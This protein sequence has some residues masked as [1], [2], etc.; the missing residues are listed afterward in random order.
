MRI[1]FLGTRANIDPRSR[2]HR[3]HAAL[4]I[5]H[6][7]RRVIIDCGRDWLGRQKR[8]HADAIVVTHAHPDHVVGLRQG[9]ACPVYAT[10]TTWDRIGHYPIDDRNRLRVGK[11]VNVCGLWFEAFSVEHSVRAPAVGLR[12]SDERT[13]IFYCPDLARIHRRHA[14]LTGITAYIGDGA[15]ISRPILK[16]RDGIEIGHASILT[17]LKWCRQEGV[18][19]AIF[20][21]C[22]TAIVES[23][24]ATMR[25]LT[26]ELSREF[27][28][29][30]EIAYDG[31]Q[32]TTIGRPRISS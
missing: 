22:G 17:Q 32:I 5:E 14:A 15:T 6:R 7:R 18:K 21:H 23:N 8:L 20:T 29:R 28:V 19:R 10:Q 4:L 13:T 3:R 27:G 9:A 11:P 12:V 24:R 31:M 25:A 1:T 16:R 26:Q 2:E 30:V